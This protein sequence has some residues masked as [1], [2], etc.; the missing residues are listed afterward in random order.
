MQMLCLKKPDT[1][2]TLGARWWLA[3][4]LVCRVSIGFA[5]NSPVEINNFDALEK[6]AIQWSQTHPAFR[7]KEVHVAP[8]DSRIEVQNCQQ[9][10]QFEQPFVGQAS[11][12]VRCAKP[13]WQLFVTLMTG[14]EAATPNAS[15]PAAR[16]DLH[17]VLVPR[18]VLKRG[19]FISPDMFTYSEMP[20]AGM[21]SQLITDKALLTNMELLR[22]LT[23]STPLRTYD[24]KAA[25]LV[26]RGKDILVTAGEGK[27]FAITIRAEAMQDG[28]LGDQIRLKNLDSGRSLSGVV[29]GLGTAKLR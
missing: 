19:T 18:E 12:R 8:L 25:V 3:A 24:V 21:E 27:G 11:I 14:N 9:N 10:L 7:G 20:A 16:S 23:P 22:D 2:R 4:T 26:K 17:K 5:A 6:Q 28:A 29:T 15:Q 1:R 13:H